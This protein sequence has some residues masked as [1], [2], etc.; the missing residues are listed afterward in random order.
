MLLDSQKSS[1]Q[2]SGS[3]TNLELAQSLRHVLIVDDSRAQVMMMSRLLGRWGLNVSVATSGKD[4][5]E[6]VRRDPPDLVLSDWVMPEM[7]GLE[8]CRAFRENSTSKFGY[9]I[10]LTSK[11]DKAEIAEG[12]D[13]GADDFL[14]KPVHANELRARINA[15]ARI[16]SMQRELTRKNHLVS[17]TLNELRKAYDAI[18]RDLQQAR[19]IQDSLVPDRTYR[20]KHAQI[21]MLLHPCGHVGGD[22]VGAFDTGSAGVGFY[23]IDVSGHGIC[24]A[25][26]AA[27]VAGYLSDKFKEQNIALSQSPDGLLVKEPVDVAR[28]LNTRLLVDSG[29]EEYLTMAFCTIDPL[30]K[31]LKMVQAGHPAPLLLRNGCAPEFIGK[32]GLPIGLINDASHQQIEYDLEAGDKLLIYSDGFVE[33]ELPDGSLLDD[34]GLLD[35]VSETTGH[36]PDYLDALYQNLLKT[37]GDVRDDDVSAVLL[38]VF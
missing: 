12:L 23:G 24:S 8:F 13:A 35:L 5:L 10:L 18:D 19:R 36:G 29:V 16:V 14:T 37:A 15:A 9:F 30:G 1:G 11:S 7:D 34:D 25:M 4:A 20:T 32:G 38:E 28:E 6:I 17:D 33:A 21:S 22:L 26:V 31:K 2:Y 27:R 3:V